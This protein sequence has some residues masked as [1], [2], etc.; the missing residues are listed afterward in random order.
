MYFK[1]FDKL[2]IDLK[3]EILSELNLSYD[4]NSEKGLNALK[5]EFKEIEPMIRKLMIEKGLYKVRLNIKKLNNSMRE[6]EKLHNE[7][8]NLF[9]EKTKNMLYFVFGSSKNEII[10]KLENEYNLDI[11]NIVSI[12]YGGYIRKSDV[13]K[14]NDLN[15]YILEKKSEFLKKDK[16]N[17]CGLFLDSL[18]NYESRI[19][20]DGYERAYNDLICYMQ[21][22]K[23]KDDKLIDMLNSTIDYYNKEFDKLNGYY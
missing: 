12:G 16:Y 9:N 15:K 19:G 11:N 1:T 17:C 8:Q 18:W 23:I 10:S 2:D 3:I 20:F 14:F 13:K 22:D 5:S 6:Y 7:L 4:L 21:V